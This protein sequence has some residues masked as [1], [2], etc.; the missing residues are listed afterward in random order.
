[1]E[2]GMKIIHYPD[3]DDLD[4]KSGVIGRFFKILKKQRPDLWVL[5]REVMEKVK[6]S[7]DLELFKRQKIVDHISYSK[8][9]LYE[10]RI[11]PKKSGGVVRLYFA[12]K[13]NDPKVI[14]ILSAEL[15]KEKKASPEKIKQ[16]EQRYQEVCQ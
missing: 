12:H 15:K 16:A 6:K 9:P 2:T 5:V 8:F 14:V 4:D 13:E 7:P 3:Q 1:M 10:F 11:P